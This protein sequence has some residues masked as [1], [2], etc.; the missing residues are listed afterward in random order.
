ME[1]VLDEI[2]LKDNELSAKD[3]VRIRMLNGFAEVP[4][5]HAA[6]ALKNGLINVS[7]IY[8]G[9][10]IGMGRMVGDGAMYWYLQEIMVV[11]EYQR[12]GIGTLIVN[13]LP[14]KNF[15]DWLEKALSEPGKSLTR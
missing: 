13:H 9:K 12:M 3:F 14:K 4:E 5:E 11:P 2:K 8:R 7:A 6:K 1:I 10:L 15:H